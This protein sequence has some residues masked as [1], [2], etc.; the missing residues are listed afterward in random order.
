MTNP[1]VSIGISAYNEEANIKNLLESLLKQDTDGY[2]LQEII[3]ISDAST[4]N[5][6]LKIKEVKNKV[7]KVISNTKRLGKPLN[8]NKVT[9]KTKG[10]I[11][12]LLDADILPFDNQ[13]IKKIIEPI[14]NNSRIGIVG[15]KL[16][17]VKAS[18][19]LEKIINF[20]VYLKIDMFESWNKGNNLYSC[21][22]AAR[23]FSRDFL[24]V[25]R[26]RNFSAEDVYSYLCLK[27]NGFIFKYQ[28]EAL[29]YFKSPTN[30]ADHLKQNERF[31]Q[32]PK[33]LADFF[34]KD[35]VYDAYKIPALIMAKSILKFFFINPLLL[36]LYILLL[37]LTRMLVYFIPLTQTGVWKTAKTSKTLLRSPVRVTVPSR[38]D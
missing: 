37:L 20:S 16:V 32:G 1:K 17:P 25:F 7:V 6:V 14:R 28:K 10:D 38:I 33:N 26:W 9:E 27:K 34:E 24:K 13:F 22:G 19:F 15:A 11:V 12:V 35:F 36:C 5:T 8:L 23:A 4:D 30:L 31:V 2:I 3:V 29:V 21:R 18:T